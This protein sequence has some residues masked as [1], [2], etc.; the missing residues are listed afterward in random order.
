MYYFDWLGQYGDL[1]VSGMLVTVQLTLVGT[2]SGILFGTLFAWALTWGPRWTHPPITAYVEFIRN[3]PFMIQ[4]FF[5]FF[6]LPQLGIRLSPM[7]AAY[8]AMGTYLAAYS[9]EIIRAGLAAT[10]SGQIEAGLSLAMSRLQVFF[11]VCLQP[12]FQRIWPALSSQIVIGMLG[13]A[14]VSLIS[15]EDLSYATSF[16]ETRNFRAFETYLF[17]TLTF[18]VMAACLRSVLMRMPALI[19]RNV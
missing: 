7:Q 18:L 5:L 19:F 13:S 16:I 2:I 3:T 11:Y 14:V 10:P 6:G 9:T 12:A 4:L 17:S 15:V 1:I 8:L